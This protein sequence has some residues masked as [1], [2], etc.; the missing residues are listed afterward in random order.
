M[1]LPGLGDYGQGE[2]GSRGRASQSGTEAGV[3]LCRAGTGALVV[4]AWGSIWP[5]QAGPETTGQ[6][7]WS[8]WRALGSS[9]EQVALPRVAGAGLEVGGGGGHTGVTPEGFLE[10]HSSDLSC[11]SPVPVRWSG[12]G[13]LPRL[14]ARPSVGRKTSRCWGQAWSPPRPPPAAPWR[15]PSCQRVGSAMPPTRASGAGAGLMASEWPGLPQGLGAGRTHGGL[16]VSGH[17]PKA[18]IPAVMWSVL[19]VPLSFS[20][21]SLDKTWPTVGVCRTQSRRCETR[22]WASVRRLARRACS[23]FPGGGRAVLTC[24]HHRVAAGGGGGSLQTSC[25]RRS[26]QECSGGAVSP[27][28]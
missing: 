8:G 19:C 10:G 4:P 20:L 18:L 15:T 12:G 5:P 28:L 13:R 9:R 17:E 21:V 22:A 27:T 24:A 14:C 3:S 2:P 1:G 6:E 26:S 23:L 7:L 11:V 16:M 25:L